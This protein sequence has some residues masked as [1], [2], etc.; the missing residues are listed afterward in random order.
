MGKN[1]DECTD[2]KR[3][4]KNPVALRNHRCTLAKCPVCKTKYSP[5]HLKHHVLSCIRWK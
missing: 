4:F 5:S 3:S 1:N 2:C